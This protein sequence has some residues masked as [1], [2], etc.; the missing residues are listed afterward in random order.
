[1]EKVFP[2]E[3]GYKKPPPQ[4]K[5]FATS[6]AELTGE[7]KQSINRSVARAESIGPDLLPL[8]P[9]QAVLW[10]VGAFCGLGMPLG[11]MALCWQ[12]SRPIHSLPTTYPQS[13]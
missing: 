3:I 10:P 5:G 1:V 11:G 9:P 8:V 2:P 7:T 4:T 6:T 12:L 13:C